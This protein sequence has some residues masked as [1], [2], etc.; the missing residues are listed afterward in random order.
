MVNSQQ[1]TQSP[2]SPAR[3]PHGCCPHRLSSRAPPVL[4]VVRAWQRAAPPS[5]V[6]PQPRVWPALLAVSRPLQGCT[7][8]PGFGS[9][10]HCLIFTR[11]FCSHRWSGSIPRPSA[12]HQAPAHCQLHLRRHQPDEQLRRLVSHHHPVGAERY[13]AARLVSWVSLPGLLTP[14]PCNPLCRA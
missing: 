10:A 2:G 12:E 5:W 9:L 6:T 3:C 1:G 13:G 11:H 8:R 4:R 7:C 14:G